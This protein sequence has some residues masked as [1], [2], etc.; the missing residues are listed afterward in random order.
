LPKP[1]KERS[2]DKDWYNTTLALIQDAAPSS[3]TSVQELFEQYTQDHL[4]VSAER[5]N[6][7]ALLL[8]LLNNPVTHLNFEDAFLA[9]TLSKH[10]FDFFVEING[11]TLLQ[12]AL[13]KGGTFFIAQT[14]AREMQNEKYVC[15]HPEIAPHV[16]F[17][18]GIEIE[19]PAH[20]Q[21]LRTYMIAIIKWQIIQYLKAL[22]HPHTQPLDTLK[23]IFALFS[24]NT[25]KC[26]LEFTHN[27]GIANQLGNGGFG[28]IL[29]IYEGNGFRALKLKK[30]L[31]NLAEEEIPIAERTSEQEAKIQKHEKEQIEID[32]QQKNENR[33]LAY[34]LDHTQRKMATNDAAAM[35]IANDEIPFTSYYRSFD[36]LDPTQGC[37]LSLAFPVDLFF[38][39]SPE[40]KSGFSEFARLQSLLD[41]LNAAHYLHEVLFIIHRDLKPENFVFDVANGRL[42][43]CDF[44]T[45]IGPLDQKMLSDGIKAPF[46]GSLRYLSPE[47]IPI[48]P[49]I[50]GI[51]GKATDKFAIGTIMHEL[52]C[53]NPPAERLDNDAEMLHA[54]RNGRYPQANLPPNASPTQ[55]KFAQYAKR[56]WAQ[57]TGLTFVPLKDRTDPID[58]NTLATDIKREFPEHKFR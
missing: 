7:L 38:L 14:I 15:E 55:N 29:A 19:L 33:I 12:H 10:P 16:H 32:N 56:F 57:R 17:H 20:R 5:K 22:D 53:G 54:I 31:P 25:E 3:P 41:I 1:P 23:E 13:K 37:F 50:Q 47:S 28:N 52:M 4:L 43:L 2:V 51:Y 21:R 26:E 30:T 45:A 44:G 24:L 42:K 9:T 39:L 36:I 48:R 58:L 46:Q 49:N 8:Y 27:I 11:L 34:I 35:A 40:N 6:T 18:I